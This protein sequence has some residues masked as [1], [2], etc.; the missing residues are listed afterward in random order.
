M[1]NLQNC[2]TVCALISCDHVSP[3]TL[4]C[5]FVPPHKHSQRKKV[6]AAKAKEDAKRKKEEE[7]AAKKRKAEA[8]V[9]KQRACMASFF[10]ASSPPRSKTKTSADM[11]SSPGS[12]GSSKF[13]SDA[14]WKSL[15]MED[16]PASRPAPF[17]KLSQQAKE[18][19]KRKTKE[20]AV[21]VFATV[22]P[23]NPFDQQPYDE[24]RI[25]KVPNKYKFLAFHEDYRPPYYGT[26]S[27]PRS[28]IVTGRNPLGRDT[29][30]LDYDVDSE[31][32]WEEGDD[33]EGEDCEIDGPDDDDDE[34][35]KIDGEEGDTRMYNYDDGWLAQ[36][37][38]YDVED[39]EED[40]DEDTLAMRKR[41]AAEAA[42]ANKKQGLTLARVCV[43][44]PVFGGIPLVEAGSDVLDCPELVAEHVDGT[45]VK[46]GKDL[47]S[48]HKAFDFMP[49]SEN[50]LDLFP[51]PKSKKSKKATDKDGSSSSPAKAQASKEMS[52]DDLR[53][54]AKF[55]HN[56]TLGSKD[57]VIEELQ[58]ALPDITSSRAQATRKLDSIA[59]KRR[60]KYG[61]GVVW[62]VKRA[63]L[64]SL[65]LQADDLVSF[66]EGLSSYVMFYVAFCCAYQ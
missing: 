38:E 3:S 60:L 10:G 28:S 34:E 43:V 47:L 32:E 37:D 39:N 19:R 22:M 25:L 50:C 36:D 52:Q 7:K 9:E 53:A 15:G 27:K 4:P 8:K 26:W 56:S 23:D 11:N 65:N 42:D 20:V 14:F 59:E 49:S 35:D 1:R 48:S 63:V 6:E 16:S 21:T 13:D 45:E 51:T 12:A 18:S 55:V 61:G 58:T 62:E 44:A 30:F 64:E 66:S 54:F 41:K 2:N 31:A 29:D 40:N 57:K 33:E 46:I 17:K 5:P 24:E